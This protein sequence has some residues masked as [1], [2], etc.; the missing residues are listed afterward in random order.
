M[1]VIAADGVRDMRAVWFEDGR[2]KLIDQRRLPLA[3]EIV[4][5]ADWRQATEIIRDMTVRGAP[6]IG[7]TAAYAMILSRPQRT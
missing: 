4:E 1:K 5:T 6:A 3:L 7:I 2:L